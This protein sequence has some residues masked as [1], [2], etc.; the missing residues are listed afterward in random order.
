MKFKM[1]VRMKEGTVPVPPCRPCAE[2][3]WRSICSGVIASGEPQQRGW[4]PLRSVYPGIEHFSRAG[5][6]NHGV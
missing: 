4:N 1:L 5:S 2:R 6:W 3:W